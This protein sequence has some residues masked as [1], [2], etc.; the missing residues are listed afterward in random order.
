MRE[1]ERE[2]MSR[3]GCWV[4]G[5]MKEQEGLSLEEIRNIGGH[6]NWDIFFHLFLFIFIFGIPSFYLFF[7]GGLCGERKNL[8]RQVLK[9]VKEP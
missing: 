4:G 5:P 6:N 8:V 1:R 7:S 9:S 2:M 3:G